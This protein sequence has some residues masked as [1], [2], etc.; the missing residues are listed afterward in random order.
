M[1]N[2]HKHGV[3]TDPPAMRISVM[4][5]VSGENAEEGK[6]DVPDVSSAVCFG[7]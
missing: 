7:G 6:G 2:L 5:A 4:R 1:P 3:Q